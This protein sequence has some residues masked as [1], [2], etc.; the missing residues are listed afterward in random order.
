MSIQTDDFLPAPPKRVV[1]AVP[2]SKQE[3]AIE[4]ALWRRLFEKLNGFDRPVH[5]DEL[6]I[7]A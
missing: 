4:Q 6:D 1:S 7:D 2:V 5:S 3:D